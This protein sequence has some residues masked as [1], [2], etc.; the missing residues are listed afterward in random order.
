MKENKTTYKST[1]LNFAYEIIGMQRRID[2]LTAENDRLK[3]IEDKYNKLLNDS[4]KHGNVMMGNLV[5]AIIN[6]DQFRNKK[7]GKK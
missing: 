4:I 7:G 5:S 6:P 1:T 3:E 2:F